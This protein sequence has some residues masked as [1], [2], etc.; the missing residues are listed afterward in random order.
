M[1]G[2]P[3]VHL[4]S[5]QNLRNPTRCWVAEPKP[6]L[7]FLRNPIPCGTQFWVPRF[8]EEP[9]SGFREEPSSR[10]LGSLK[11]L[12]SGFHEEPLTNP[13]PRLREVP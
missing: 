1:L 9:R 13:E 10:F 8:R 3:L 11:N 5:S 6:V 7:G 12:G 2:F 4:G